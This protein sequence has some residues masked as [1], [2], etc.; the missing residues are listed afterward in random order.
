MLRVSDTNRRKVYYFNNDRRMDVSY[1]NNSA[2]EAAENR[3]SSKH[4][5]V[6]DCISVDWSVPSGETQTIFI[7]NGIE[8]SFV[9]GFVQ[10][11]SGNPEFVK[12]RFYL[13]SRQVG[14]TVKVFEESSFTFN[15]TNFDRIT[16]ECP[17]FTGT[18]DPDYSDVCEGELSIITRYSV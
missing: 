11:A 6:R 7:K 4:K 10:Y 12:V 3:C 14:E 13:G 9:S 2:N 16:V 18:S 17:N 15:F 8:Q 5:L 1:R